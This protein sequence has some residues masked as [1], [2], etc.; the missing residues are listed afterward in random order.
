M[1]G[2]TLVPSCGPI[3]EHCSADNNEEGDRVRIWSSSLSPLRFAL[4]EPTYVHE[5][6]RAV[7]RLTQFTIFWRL[8]AIALIF[9]SASVAAIPAAGGSGP[10][11]AVTAF[12]NDAGAP[13]STLNTLSSALYAAVDQSG[14]FTAVGGGPLEVTQV[15]G[16][17]LIVN[18]LDGAK[19]A[20]A[21]EIVTADLIS[22]SGGSV[23]YRLSAYRVDPLTFIRSSLFT[24]SSL[25]SQA[26]T[27]GF[28]TNLATLH[29]PRTAVG[30]IYSLQ[31]GVQADMGESSGAKLGD[32]YNV[33]RNGQKMAQAKI[34][35]IDLNSATVDIMNPVAGYKP[36]VGDSLVGIGPSPPIP[37]AANTS[38]NTFS[39]VGLVV[40]TGAALL[41]IGH[42]GQPATIGSPQP[43][44]SPTGI[45]GFSVSPSGQSGTPPS[46][47]FNFNF[48][49][50]VNTSIITF[51]V[52]TYVSYEK[53]NSGAVITPAGTPVTNLGGPTPSF[54]STGTTLT[55]SATTLNPGDQLIFSFTSSILSTLG[56]ALTPTNITFTASEQHHPL[57]HK[58]VAVP[59]PHQGGVLQGAAG[60]K[61]QPAPG[62]GHNPNNPH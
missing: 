17:D 47:T 36:A 25:S 29:A 38:V 5:V 9:V 52:P 39:I 11:M 22:A 27:A 6:K 35:A 51:T 23:S 3:A 12:N 2:L 7:K 40:A 19:K 30:S 24:Q 8:V 33:V 16:G 10:T 56:V 42:H 53:T 21:E 48:T 14:K 58:H 61:P 28:V 54:N 15:T 32:E 55:I 49:Q 50:P 4:G 59:A 20:G 34:V 31:N 18:A 13:A 57:V 26:L 45:G 41:A 37:P 44:P 60:T 1:T 46:E 43:S 62:G